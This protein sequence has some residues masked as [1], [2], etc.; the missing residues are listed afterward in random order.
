MTVADWIHAAPEIDAALA[1]N[2]PVVALETAVVSHGVPHEDALAAADRM[3]SAVRAAGG[4]PAFVGVVRGRIEIGMARSD[5]AGLL[6][7]GA[8]KIAERDLAV[9][10]AAQRTGGT[11]VSATLAVAAR[12]GVR[13]MATGGIG[14]VHYGVEQ[15]GD[16]SADLA[17]MSRFPVV[18]V[19]AGPKAI[20]DPQRTIEALDSLGVPVLGYRTEMLPAFLSPSSGVPVP[21][22]V[23]SAG[24]VASI[25]VAQH[26]M[27]ASSALLVVQ[28]P[29]PGAA[30]DDRELREAVQA[31]LARSR[32]AGVRAAD[33]TPFLLRALT[34]ITGGR[35]LG[36]NIAVLEANARLAGEIARALS[37][38]A[39]SAA[40]PAR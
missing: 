17:A 31:A 1:A 30:M 39:T 11:T 21:H 20:C 37:A 34:E 26:R 6:A 25:A 24:E 29:P 5:L 32:E 23:E 19:S 18:V 27:G 40:P 38:R 4:I 12:R 7:P 8:V 36:A 35:S 16:I 28:P 2:G 14:G 15:T 33:L 3:E 13:V 22:R 9:A 10:A